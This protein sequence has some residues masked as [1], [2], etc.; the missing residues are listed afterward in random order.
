MK[1]LIVEDEELAVKKLKRTLGAVDQQAEARSKANDDMA[2][3]FAAAMDKRVASMP[4]TLDV[5]V[6][7]QS[8]SALLSVD[9]R[10]K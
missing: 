9:V 8:F 3:R 10:E 6:D 4:A 5:L 1:I 2:D 7:G